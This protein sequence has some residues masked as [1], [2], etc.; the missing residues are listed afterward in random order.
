VKIILPGLYPLLVVVML[1]LCMVTPGECEAPR[2]EPHPG[3]VRLA[4]TVDDLPAHGDLAPRWTRATVARAV[5]KSLHDNGI[6]QAYGFANGYMEKLE[7]GVDRVLKQWLEAGYPLGNHT[8]NHLNLDEV[9]ARAY[10]ADIARMDRLLQTFAPVSPLIQRRD[11]FRYPHLAEGDTLEKRDAVRSY[12]SRNGYRIAEVTVDYN[13]WAWDSAYVRCAQQSDQKSI[14][15][16]KTHILEDA[17]W[18]LNASTAMAEML[19]HRNV[20][21]ILLVHVGVF[22]A[23]MLDKVLKDLRAHHVKFITLDEALS[24]PVY[25]INANRGFAG[26][27]TFL[28]EI[29]DARGVDVAKYV[30]GNYPVQKLEAICAQRRTSN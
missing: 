14:A 25:K 21:Q 30:D 9:P 5:L 1:S 13:D 18:H 10:I 28:K 22:D 2:A 20:P 27:E 11:V 7:P 19:F 15:W 3:V 4:V 26:G 8:Y 23:V 12:L 29:A 17:E 24:D 16:L 6:T